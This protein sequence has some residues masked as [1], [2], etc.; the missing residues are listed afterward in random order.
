[1]CKGRAYAF[2]ELMLY[3]AVIISMYEIQPAGGKGEWPTFK[4]VKQAATKHPAG[5]CRVWIKRRE[6]PMEDA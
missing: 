5:K 2:R 3:S 6:L 1:M 4:T